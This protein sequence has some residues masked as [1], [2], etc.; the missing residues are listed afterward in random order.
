[1]KLQKRFNRKVAGKEYSKWVVNLPP[2]EVER[3]GWEE[4]VD[5]EATI[6]DDKLIL[7]SKSGKRVKIT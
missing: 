5:L 3:L 1:M 7:K 6:K 4:G 2:E